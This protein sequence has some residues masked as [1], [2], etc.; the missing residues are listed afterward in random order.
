[1]NCL[2]GSLLI[3]L[4]LFLVLPAVAQETAEPPVLMAQFGPAED[5]S[6][7]ENASQP[8]K[9]TKVEEKAAEKPAPEKAGSEKAAK[10]AEPPA[11]ATV[12][13]S[14]IDAKPKKPV[15]KGRFG[16]VRAN[17]L[18]IAAD[19]DPV[20]ADRSKH[21]VRLEFYGNGRLRCTRSLS[22]DE[23]KS[24]VAAYRKAAARSTELKDGQKSF[25]AARSDVII[26]AIG[27]D[28]KDD[29]KAGGQ[30]KMYLYDKRAPGAIVLSKA[31]RQ[32]FNDVIDRTNKYFGFATSS[33][34]KIPLPKPPYKVYQRR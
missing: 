14:T 7:A 4:S 27:T 32:E 3:I 20:S 28:K 34:K 1:M 10:P 21:K 30:V 16:S 25:V 33:G 9:D 12:E 15:S 2:R 11:E 24:L 22:R 26:H 19:L 23:W 31:E 13:A 5:E 18:E 17:N 29:D 8:E 6:E